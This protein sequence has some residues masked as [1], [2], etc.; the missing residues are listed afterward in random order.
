[1]AV[2]IAGGGVTARHLPYPVSVKASKS[3]TLS[4]L[5]NRL[6]LYERANFNVVLAH[7]IENDTFASFL[8]QTLALQDEEGCDADQGRGPDCDQGNRPAVHLEG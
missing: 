8:E 6:W 1:M 4:G 5:Q 2:A 7:S 3:D